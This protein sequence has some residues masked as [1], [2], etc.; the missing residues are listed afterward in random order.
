M[1]STSSTGGTGSQLQDLGGSPQWC[2]VA[3][4]AR[5][6]RHGPGG[7]QVQSGLKHFA[8]GAKLWVLPPRYGNEDDQLEVIGFHRAGGRRHIPLIV[9]RRHLQNF[10]IKAVYSPAVERVRDRTNWNWPHVWCC[11]ELAQPWVDRW[12]A[13]AAGQSMQAFPPWPGRSVFGQDVRPCPHLST[14]LGT[15]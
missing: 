3:N 6:T 1:S 5:E 15:D 2:V 7:E 12:N 11:P 8:P 4:V 9:F 10:R 14:G 13:L